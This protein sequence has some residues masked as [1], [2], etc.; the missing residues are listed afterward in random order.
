[1][2]LKKSLE[3]NELEESSISKLTRDIL[4][5]V[6]HLHDNDIIHGN[7]KAANVFIK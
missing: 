5:G 4:K 7:I 2:T 1:M 3:L 6:K